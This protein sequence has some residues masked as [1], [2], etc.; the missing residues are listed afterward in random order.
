MGVHRKGT[1]VRRIY[2]ALKG[3]ILS[4]ELEPGTE[5]EE[6]HL[7][8]SL[9]VSRTPI[10]EA[11]VR[12]GAEGLV[13]LMPN[14]GA[15]VAPMDLTDLRQ[16][17]EALDLCQ[18]TLTRYA[19]LRRRDGEIPEI[20][21]ALRAFEEAA[22]RGDT[23]GMIEQNR[24]F[25]GL[26]GAAGHNLYLAEVNSRLLTESLRIARVC[27]AYEVEQGDPLANHLDQTIAD[28]RAILDAIRQRDGDTAEGLAGRHCDLFR[29]RV[30]QN[31]T[32]T[33]STGGGFPSRA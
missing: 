14:Q 8:K 26:I 30:A 9:G 25:H 29:R 23:D 10:R 28:H 16:F 5:L 27:F 1:G 24:R 4:L 3:R 20:E 18:R 22:G 7:A 15:R 12:L 33:D 2:D 17:F 19:A 21:K 6:I 31:L 11:L 32:G 13:T